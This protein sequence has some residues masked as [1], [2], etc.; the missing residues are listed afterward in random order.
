MET[1]RNF[2][3]FEGIDGTGTSTQAAILTKRL[4]TLARPSSWVTFEPTSGPIGS[5][6]RSALSGTI[7]MH[8][9]TVARLFAADRNEHLYGKDGIVQRCARGELVVSDRYVLSSL[10]YQGLECGPSLPMALNDDYPAPELTLYFEITPDLAVARIQGREIKDSYECLEFQQR[11]KLRYEEVL[12]D[13]S[14]KGGR[15]V[16]IDAALSVEEVSESVW[17]ELSTLPILRG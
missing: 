15:I 13:Y 8:R 5:L 4:G 12:D 1:L 2:V 3:A 16:R 17:R 11:V 9:E 10:A 6:V 7:P 14:A